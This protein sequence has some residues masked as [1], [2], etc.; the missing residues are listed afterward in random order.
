M[1]T[2][3]TLLD[4]PLYDALTRAIAAEIEFY[5]SEGFTAADVAAAGPTDGLEFEVYLIGDLP[6]HEQEDGAEMAR[7]ELARIWADE[8]RAFDAARTAQAA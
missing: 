8:V 7:D 2:L 4:S 1:A 6:E 3:S 5:E